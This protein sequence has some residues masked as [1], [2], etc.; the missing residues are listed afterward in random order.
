MCDCLITKENEKNLL[1]IKFIT[2]FVILYS[3]H[4][5]LIMG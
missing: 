3:T 4:N 1:T 5:E 2:H